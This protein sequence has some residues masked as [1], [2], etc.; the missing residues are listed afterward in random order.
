MRELKLDSGK[1]QQYLRISVKEVEANALS[2]SF[3][4]PEEQDITILCLTSLAI[5]T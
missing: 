2:I 5:L 3:M 1:L 4:F